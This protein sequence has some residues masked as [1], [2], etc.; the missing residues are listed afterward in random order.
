MK[1]SSLAVATA[2]IFI[3]IALIPAMGNGEVETITTEDPDTPLKGEPKYIET[4]QDG[5]LILLSY[6]NNYGISIINRNDNT[7]EHIT[8]PDISFRRG[9]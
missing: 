5:N 6:Q 8:E 7:I 4:G 2:F 1:E 3:F 9:P